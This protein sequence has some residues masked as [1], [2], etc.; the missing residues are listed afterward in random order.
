MEKN[1]ILDSWIMVEQLSEGEI[2]IKNKSKIENWENIDWN[3]FFIKEVD[4]WIK[5]ENKKN[6]KE[7]DKDKINII[8]YVDIFKFEDILEELRNI[9]NL[10]KPVEIKKSGNKFAIMLV[11]E[12]SELKD[13]EIF[14]KLKDNEIFINLLQYF[15]EKKKLPISQEFKDFE[16][17][18]KD[19]LSS[20]F[21]TDFSNGFKKL[22]NTYNL[23]KSN[24]CYEITEKQNINL[25]SFLIDDLRKAK[26]KNNEKLKRYLFGFNEEKRKNLVTKD[27]KDLS[28]EEK[29][30]LRE[31]LQPKNYPLGR[32]PSNPKYALS[33]MQQIAVNLAIKEDDNEDFIRS[34]NGPPGTGKTTLLKDIFA[35][36][37]VKV[38]KNIVDLAEKKI[39]PDPELYYEYKYNNIIKTANL[40][41]LP[42]N[43]AKYN[44]VVASSNNGAVQNIVNELPLLKEIDEI[45]KEDIKNANYFMEIANSRDENKN[46]GLFSLEGGKRDNLANLQNKLESMF[47]ELNEL[48]KLSTNDKRASKVYDEF[49]HKYKEL[50]KIRNNMQKYNEKLRKL[51]KLEELVE[52]S[53]NDNT[54]Q[55]DEEVRNKKNEFE[56]YESHYNNQINNLNKEIQNILFRKKQSEEIIIEINKNKEKL[57]KAQRN[58]DILNDKKPSLMDKIFS[59]NKVYNYE[60]KKNQIEEDLNIIRKTI[61]NL[62]SN[63]EEI[64]FDKEI[65]DRKNLIFQIEEDKRNHKEKLNNYIYETEKVIKDI[66]EL[67]KEIQPYFEKELDFDSIKDYRELQLFNPWFNEDFRKLQSK[68]FILALKV[69]KEFLYKNRYELKKACKKWK[70][71]YKIINKENGKELVDAAWQWVN[72]AIPL[73]ST[74][75]ASFGRMFKYLDE[76]SISNLFVD[77]AGQALPYASVG[78]IFRSRKIMV[79]GDPAQ[80]K[81]VWIA[82][83]KVLGII[84]DIY[85]INAENQEKYLSNNSSTQT[86]VDAASKYGF[87]KDQKEWIGIPLWVHRRC[88]RPMFDISNKISYN[89]L[90]VL[91]IPK[92]HGK[93]EW[94]DVKGVADDK[95]VKKQADFLKEEINKKLKEIE[96]DLG[97]NPENKDPREQI[98]V[99]TPFTNVK[100]KLVESLGDFVIQD[101]EKVINVGTVHTFQGKEAPIVYFVL[102]ADEKSIGAAKWAV[103]EAN[104]LNVAA[105]RA[106]KEFYVIGDKEL[107]DSFK[108]CASDCIE[109]IQKYNK[110]IV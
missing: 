38:A 99:I 88:Y 64:N 49:N 100:N 81:P 7:I 86:L 47:S 22:I 14:L 80:I 3:E 103:D 107:Y 68:L 97:D 76:N 91:G 35:E 102:G 98:Y 67:K 74:T 41:K 75:F 53:I 70:D 15:R 17:E 71:R 56:L 6:K 33:F 10:E 61:E 101:G 93:S 79:V 24:F 39:S 92:A 69:R 82:E 48:S 18:I 20:Y 29:E 23:N 78:A 77:E 83:D 72:F 27:P 87:Y 19:K 46:W 109:E 11:F 84:G 85:K 5:E 26:E 44:M 4:N 65:E 54:Q 31:I 43:I 1:N 66:K 89:N 104:I 36:Y 51:D 25:H 2:K 59:K 58:F 42:E 37:I 73:I 90:M 105:T 16:S 94:Y 9:Y 13:E 30:L 55:I 34:I 60:N 62:K 21:Q 110:I 45:F 57:I 106:K 12:Y 40:T 108:L 28:F 8:F 96:R 95:F 52:K 32:F 63:L 50:E